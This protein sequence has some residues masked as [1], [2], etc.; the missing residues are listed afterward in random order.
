MSKEIILRA[1]EPQDIDLIY[2]WENDPE[3]WQQS[4]SHVPFSRHTLTQYVI[5]SASTDIYSAKQLRLMAD[6]AVTGHTVGCI[7]LSSFDPYHRRAEIGMLI[8][9]QFRGQGYGR[10]IVEALVS[11]CRTSLQ[12]HQLY[13]DIAVNNAA[14]VR[15]YTSL[16]FRQQGIRTD[17]VWTPGG[18][19]DAIL[20]SKIID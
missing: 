3:V 6:D 2:A 20:F 13:C 16:G 17:W 8:D 12:L 15:L 4:I 10:P 1:L 5:E 14:S 7:D 18:Y 9:R 11:F 19:V